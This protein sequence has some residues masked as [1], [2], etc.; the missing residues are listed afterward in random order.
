[1]PSGCR[2]SLVLLPARLASRLT[3]GSDV[4][5]QVPP[6]SASAPLVSLLIEDVGS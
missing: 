5:S 3:V 2:L 6:P 1:M 4:F